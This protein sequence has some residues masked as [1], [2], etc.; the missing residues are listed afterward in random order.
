M[1]YQRVK[2]MWIEIDVTTTLCNLLHFDKKYGLGNK[3]ALYK[4]LILLVDA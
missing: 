4:D 3:I 2:V 1:H